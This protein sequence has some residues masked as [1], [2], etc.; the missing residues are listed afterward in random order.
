MK[1]ITTL[2]LSSVFALT[3]VA[4]V[5]TPHADAHARVPDMSSDKSS[6][7]VAAAAETHRARETTVGAH[8]DLEFLGDAEAPSSTQNDAPKKERATPQ[9]QGQLNIN[10]A[11]SA[12][13]QLLPGVGPAIAGRIL[14]YREK[15]SFADPLQL[16]RVKG[17][18]RKTLAKMRPY[19]SL[20][21]D[22]TLRPLP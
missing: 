11:T 12:Q 4:A 14:T 6:L 2:L 21:G 8:I 5:V 19:L 22:N 13:W 1:Q 18:G 20:K 3:A 15:R 9:F 10:T 17:I 16:L 7:V